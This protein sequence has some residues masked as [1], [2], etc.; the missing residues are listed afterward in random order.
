VE[1]RNRTG[2]INDWGSDERQNGWSDHIHDT[3][4][5]DEA[6]PLT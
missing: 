6:H 5:S 4:P 3:D 1:H 2:P